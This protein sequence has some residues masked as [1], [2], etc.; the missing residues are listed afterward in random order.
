MRV[1][2]DGAVWLVIAAVWGLAGCATAPEP[3][4]KTVE[5]KVPVAVSCVPANL[6]QEP[7]YPDTDAALRAT[8]GPDDL[9]KLLGAGRLLR[10][11]WLR[12]V[13]PV[14]KACR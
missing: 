7:S 14:L 8:A 10:N 13:R 3:V 2:M 6:R 9:I 4:I 12:E 5:V 11:Q 1:L